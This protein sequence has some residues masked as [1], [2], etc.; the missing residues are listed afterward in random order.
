MCMAIF[1]GAVLPAVMGLVADRAGVRAA[2]AVPIACF[3]YLAVL[4]LSVRRSAAA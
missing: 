1:G 2:F 3:V 4:A